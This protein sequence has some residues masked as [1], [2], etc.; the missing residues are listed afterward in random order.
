MIGGSV[1]QLARERATADGLGRFLLGS[2]VAL[3]CATNKGTIDGCGGIGYVYGASSGGVVSGLVGKNEQWAGADGAGETIRCWSS[4]RVYSDIGMYNAYQGVLVAYNLG[5]CEDSEGRATGV[6]YA[7]TGASPYPAVADQIATF[8]GHIDGNEL[9]VTAIH[10]GSGIIQVGQKLHFPNSN[11]GVIATIIALGDGTGGTGTYVL[12]RSMTVAGQDMMTGSGVYDATGQWMGLIGALGAATIGDSPF[13][14]ASGL[15]NYTPINNAVV[16]DSS[17]LTGGIAGFHGDATMEDSDNY[18]TVVGGQAT[19]GVSGNAALSS[20]K[21]YR[22]TNRG[23]ISGLS[24]TGG[25]FGSSF[26]EWKDVGN[27]GDIFCAGSDGGGVGGIGRDGSCKVYVNSGRVRAGNSAGGEFGQ[28]LAAFEIDQGY[29]LQPATAAT[30]AGPV[31][32]TR[33]AA[34]TV[35]N[36]YWNIDTTGSASATGTG[37][38]TGMTG[39]FDA[40][41]LASIPAGLT[42]SA[43]V[44]DGTFGGYPHIST[45]TPLP[46]PIVT[47]NPPL[48]IAAFASST[49]SDSSG[50][51]LPADILSGDYIWLI[52]ASQ[53]N[54]TSIPAL[55]SPPSP[56]ALAIQQ[57]SGATHGIRVS[58]HVKIADGSEGGTTITGMTVGSRGKLTAAVVMRPNNPVNG[59]TWTRLNAHCVVNGAASGVAAQSMGAATA[60]GFIIG[61]ALYDGGTPPADQISLGDDN[62]IEVAS[63]ITPSLVLR[64]SYRV[65]NV[66]AA[67]STYNG[68]TNAGGVA[69]SCVTVSLS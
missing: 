35:S 65:E 47:L 14:F 59:D 13:S 12:D 54:T 68:D 39:L 27:S 36:A 43:W 63:G 48:A 16:V 52:S 29:N 41:M 64:V 62:V 24:N 5:N 53:N 61:A 23:T 15:R 40:A 31:V 18:A 30:H 60:P 67:A 56:W 38:S 19:A 4:S 3:L 37:S 66:G 33:A 49:S 51:V 28:T 55:V 22:C 11:L 6:C 1:R 17:C 9:T 32:G 26:G 7:P 45:I 46:D 25:V 34:T 50:I 69:I 2:Q 42:D 20:S 21:G 44:R 57:T 10:G 58:A 8:A